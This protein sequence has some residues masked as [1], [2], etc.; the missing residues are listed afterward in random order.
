MQI[1]ETRRPFPDGCIV[2]GTRADYRARHPS[3]DDAA[4]VIEVSLS[5]LSLDRTTK[6]VTYAEAGIGQYVI[7]NLIDRQAEVHHDPRPDGTYG[8][9]EVVPAG[10]TVRFVLDDRALDVPLDDLLP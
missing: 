10:G 8:R 4:C 6:L 2:R 1:S 9:R 5:T 3:G 7:L